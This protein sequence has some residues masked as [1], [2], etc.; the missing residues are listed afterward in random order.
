MAKKQSKSENKI[1]VLDTNILL[2]DPECIFNF[3]SND[4]VIPQVVL[5]ELDNHKGGMSDTA[6]NARQVARYFDEILNSKYNKDLKNEFVI[7]G[8]DKIC[9]GKLT[10]FQET[11]DSLKTDSFFDR[12]KADN[13]ILAVAQKLQWDN[14]T[15]QVILVSKD[16]NVRLKARTLGIVAQDYFS[17]KVVQDSD[18]LGS[19]IHDFTHM[20][21]NQV[22]TNCTRRGEATEY[23]LTGNFS[24]V[25]VNEFGVFKTLD[26][27]LVHV[28]FLAVGNKKASAI[29]V[30]DY[31]KKTTVFGINAK[32][33]EQNMVLNLL[34]DPNIDIV[35]LLGQAGT[36]KTLLTLACALEQVIE[37]DLYDDI[38]F[39]R[40]T[41]SVGEE[42]GFLPGDEEEKKCCLGWGH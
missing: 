37:K 39:T 34:M 15:R 40:A 17:D 35:S 2:H 12:N 4:L 8:G 27:S 33:D 30:K 11:V 26:D 23:E 5:E 28:R 1:F 22:V 42:I 16:I 6:R 3:E 14:S 41:V 31:R 9:T 38:I 36:G 10:F 19:G 32:N 29:T 7:R 25:V 20:D 24:K 21:F 13:Q 18:V